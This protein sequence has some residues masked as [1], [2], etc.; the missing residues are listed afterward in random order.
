MS[1]AIPSVTTIPSAPQTPSVIYLPEIH[2]SGGAYFPELR[3]G[4]TTKAT[5]VADIASAQ[6]EDVRRVLAVDLATGTGWDASQEIAQAVLDQ[7][8]NEFF[9]VP[10]WCAD[11]LHQHL[12]VGFVAR[13]EREAA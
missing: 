13:A 1:Q 12:G 6:H 9:Q 11:F 7:V 3:T 2:S 5:L 4:D 8:L 10:T